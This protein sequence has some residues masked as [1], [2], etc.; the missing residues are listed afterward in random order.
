MKSVIN[1]LLGPAETKA[2]GVIFTSV[3]WSY[4]IYYY[5]CRLS[6]LLC[7]HDPF[8]LM[9]H[10]PPRINPPARPRPARQ[11]PVELSSLSG[12]FTMPREREKQMTPTFPASFFPQV[13]FYYILKNRAIGPRLLTLRRPRY[14][15]GLNSSRQ[16]TNISRAA[17]AR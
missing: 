7:D 15:P 5:R 14:R 9:R 6:Q 3:R 10:T 16:P 17:R 8:E 13:F 1:P 11:K 12:I 2:K 4:K